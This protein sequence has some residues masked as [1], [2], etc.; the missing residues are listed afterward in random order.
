MAGPAGPARILLWDYGNVLVRW[1]PR[2]LYARLI[3][4]PDRLAHFLA[5]VCPMSWHI[6][7]D[8]GRPMDETIPERQAQF[9]EWAD[10]IAAWKTGFGD[11]IGGVIPGSVA[12]V[13]RLAAAGVPQY[14]LSNLPSEMVETSFGPFAFP[15]LFADAI[16]SGDHGVVKPDPALFAIALA[17]MGDPSPQEVVFVDDSPANIAAAQALGFRAH[18]FVEGMDLGAVLRAEGLPA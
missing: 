14:V 9:P 16:I 17:R 10:E 7:H 3:R 11:M 12:I 2:R 18:L 1:E 6:Q 8:R 13:E 5:E 15:R 4:E